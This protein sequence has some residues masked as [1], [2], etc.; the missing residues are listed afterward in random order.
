MGAIDRKNATRRGSVRVGLIGLVVA[1]VL[2]TFAVTAKNGLPGYLPGVE[3]SSLKLAFDDAGALRPGDDIRIADV[4]AGFISSIELKDGH[5]VVTAELNGGRPVYRDATATISARSGL[6]QKYVNLDPGTKAAGDLGTAVLASSRTSSP[7][8]LDDVLG[9]LDARTR[10]AA[11]T[12]LTQTGRGAAGRGRDLNDG[13]DSL[14]TL[15]PDLGDVSEALTTDDGRDVAEMLRTADVLSRSLSGQ[16]VQIAST[17]EQ[18]D[19]TLGAIAVDDAKPLSESIEKS[20]DTLRALRPTLDSLNE[21]LRDTRVAAT[22]LEPGAASL[23]AA[24]PD[25]R[26]FLRESPSTLD[27]VPGI[28]D[29]AERAVEDLTPTL[30]GVSPVVSQLATTFARVRTP[31]S[32]L[33]PYSA[34]VLLFFQNAASALSQGDGAGRWLRFYPVLTPEAIIGTVP[35]RDPTTSRQAYPAPN[36]ARTH[37]EGSVFGEGFH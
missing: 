33:S 13:L 26:G 3:R 1:A 25:L 16:K 17:V 35:L 14:D 21:P 23:A 12:T 15:L 10:A 18:L 2:A 4:R 6:G 36:E 30:E 24:M 27:K 34:E 8:E 22:N 29:S 7:T 11:K 28:T 32:I 37:R 19:D 31:L 5:P 20:A 9:A